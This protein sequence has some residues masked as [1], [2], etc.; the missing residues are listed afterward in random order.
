MGLLLAL[1]LEVAVPLA[2]QLS[3]DE[4]VPIVEDGLSRV[5]STVQFNLVGT[6]AYFLSSS[7]A[8]YDCLSIDPIILTRLD[9][10]TFNISRPSY[11]GIGEQRMDEAQ[12]DQKRENLRMWMWEAIQGLQFVGAAYQG[13]P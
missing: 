7:S 9:I 12:G 4:N 3:V 11:E 13:S 2:I 8:P 10:I 1:E 6:Q 5:A